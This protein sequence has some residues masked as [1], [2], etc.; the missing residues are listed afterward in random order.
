MRKQM[1][2]GK[3]LFVNRIRERYAL[4]QIPCHGLNQNGA[5]PAMYPKLV[6]IMRRF[7]PSARQENAAFMRFAR[8]DY[9]G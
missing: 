5:T 6:S 9:L 3:H 8:L 2:T 7:L 1:E 4:K